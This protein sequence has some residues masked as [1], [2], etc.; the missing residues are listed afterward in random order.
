M[1]ALIVED[2]VDAIN[3]EKAKAYGASIQFGTGC[4][5]E[6]CE[7]CI[8][9]GYSEV[10]EINFIIDGIVYDTTIDKLLAFLQQEG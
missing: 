7:K 5:R 6:F 3:I 8:E 4:I 1:S 10:I 2:K 9:Q